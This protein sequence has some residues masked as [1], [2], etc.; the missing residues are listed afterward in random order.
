MLGAAW[1]MLRGCTV[2]WP[3]EPCRYDF[4]AERRGAFYRV[5]VKTTT[6]RPGPSHAVSISTTR[7]RG[8]VC[9]DVDE[10]DY[11]FIIDDQLNA[12]LIPFS[13]VAGSQQ[14]HVR[15][16]A[17][18]RVAERGQWLKAAGQQMGASA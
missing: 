6:H 4:V 14:I 17:G 9:Y 7:R 13:V 1:F 8:R 12:Y 15:R 18:Y 11:F 10:V 3:L 5:Q 16:Y 2:A